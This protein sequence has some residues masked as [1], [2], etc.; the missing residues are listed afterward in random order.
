MYIFPGIPH[1]PIPRGPPLHYK[2]AIIHA[3]RAD[4]PPTFRS[5]SAKAAGAPHGRPAALPA[6]CSSGH[7]AH[8]PHVT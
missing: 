3:A 6:R 2:E 5:E 4:I 8:A 7:R 1:L